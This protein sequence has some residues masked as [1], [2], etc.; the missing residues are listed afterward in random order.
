M[1]V[2]ALVANLHFNPFPTS[3][4]HSN[5]LT[6]WNLARCIRQKMDSYVEGTAQ[7]RS[8]DILLTGCEVSLWLAE[9]VACDLQKSFPKLNITSVSS[10]KLLGLFGQE[11]SIPSVGYPMSN[12]TTKLDNAIVIIVSHSGGTF[13]PLAVSNLLN[14]NNNVFVVTSEWDSQIGKQL[15]AVH[16]ED[17][18]MMLLFNSRVF[19]TDVGLRPAEPCSVSVAAT[20]QLLTCIFQHIAI[21]ILSNQH[22]RHASGA[23]ITEH[24]LHILE[25]CNQDNL[26]ALEEI[27]GVDYFGNSRRKRI[28][29]Y[30][31]RHNI[32]KCNDICP[33]VL[34]DM[35]RPYSSGISEF[36]L[37]L[38]LIL[39][40]HIAKVIHANNFFQGMQ[41]ILITTFKDT[42]ILLSNDCATCMSI[43]LIG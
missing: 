20:Q 28:A 34:K 9:Q 8:I 12:K 42:K 2:C 36:F 38:G 30:H 25:R 17:D 19:T 22:Y 6:A 27:V 16:N 18:H 33:R 23:V 4:Y 3:I 11:L 41:I 43:L 21:I 35:V 40:D 13:S 31:C 7:P 5:R 29:R 14:T 32:E 15:R 39:C 24:D 37:G 10:N 1:F 26:H